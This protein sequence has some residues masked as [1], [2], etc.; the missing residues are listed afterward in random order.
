MRK[1]LVDAALTALRIQR[2]DAQAKLEVTLKV[3]DVLRDAVSSPGGQGARTMRQLAAEKVAREDAEADAAEAKCRGQTA[4]GPG[5]TWS[6]YKALPPGERA[7]YYKQH[8]AELLAESGMN[9]KPTKGMSH[10]NM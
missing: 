3:R 10:A 8:R 7:D 5:G 9:H 2:D 6:R 1:E 4:K